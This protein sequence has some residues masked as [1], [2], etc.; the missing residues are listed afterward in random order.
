VSAPCAEMVLRSHVVQHVAPSR[1]K[2]PAAQASELSPCTNDH[3][4]AG[5]RG[6]EITR[7]TVHFNRSILTGST[8]VCTRSW[9]RIGVAASAH[10]CTFVR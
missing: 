9:D 2:V 7:D 6:A 8:T 5:S 1:E 3:I 4:V 10:C